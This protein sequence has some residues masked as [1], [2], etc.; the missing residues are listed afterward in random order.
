[1]D[2]PDLKQL[3]M[4]WMACKNAPGFNIIGPY[5][6]PARFVPDPQKLHIRLRLNG[7]TMQDEGTDDMIFDVARLIEFA[8]QH[9]QLYPGDIIMTGSPSG[10]GTHYGRF[11]RDGDVMEGEIDGLVG[12]QRTPCVAE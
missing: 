5:I 12:H 10:N 4:D 8:S 1:V 3:G 11:L 9:T 7:E 2:R 6:T